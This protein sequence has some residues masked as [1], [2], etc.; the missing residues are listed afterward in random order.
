MHLSPSG[1]GESSLDVL[2]TFKCNITAGISNRYVKMR[3]F[4]LFNTHEEN[5]DVFGLKVRGPDFSL[6][7]F[8]GFVLL[9]KVLL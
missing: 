2:L 9:Y 5:I 6:F 8:Q 4:M 3:S 7:S 1:A